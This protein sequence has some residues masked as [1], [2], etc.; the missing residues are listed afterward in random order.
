MLGTA[1]VVVVLHDMAVLFGHPADLLELHQV[2]MNLEVEAVLVKVQT[3]ELWFDIAVVGSPDLA[4]YRYRCDYTQ[5]D[6]IRLLVWI[7]VLAYAVA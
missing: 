2:Q 7:L 5:M 6:C 3:A 1:V 4:Q